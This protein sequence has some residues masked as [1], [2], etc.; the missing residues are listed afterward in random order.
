MQAEL[1]RLQ[2]IVT[3]Q[4]QHI[5]HVEAEHQRLIQAEAD[6]T[7]QLEQTRRE[8]AE[9]ES[10]TAWRLSHR[11]SR[12]SK[13]VAPVG[14]KRRALLVPGSHAVDQGHG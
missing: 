10:S 9:L 13:T 2:T 12:L 4:Q 14:T 3:H 7:R 1:G 8:Q 5:H 6:L 11:L